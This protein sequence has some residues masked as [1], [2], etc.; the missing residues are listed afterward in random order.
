VLDEVSTAI[1]GGAAAGNV[2]IEPPPEFMPN[3]PCS[4]TCY[5][6]QDHP[7]KMTL[8]LSGLQ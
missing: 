6:M 5:R 4:E 2:R 8:W 3:N 7:Q 1:P